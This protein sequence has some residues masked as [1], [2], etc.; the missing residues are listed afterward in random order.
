LWHFASV[1]RSIHPGASIV[2]TDV[3]PTVQLNA[4]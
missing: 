4:A 1:R 3:S 2:S